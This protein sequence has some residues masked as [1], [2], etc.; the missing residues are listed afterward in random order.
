MKRKISSKPK[1][2]LSDR[3][4]IAFQMVDLENLLPIKHRA[5]DIWNF[6][7]EMDLS[8]IYS[9]IRSIEGGAG[10]SAID[11]K[12]LMSLWIM[13]SAN[14]VGSARALDQLCREHRAYMWLC[15]GVSVNYHTLSDFRI[16]H[17]EGLNSLLVQG[18]AA[19]MKSG[20]LKLK[21]V[22]QDGMKI[23]ANSG[24]A[25]L[26]RQE[27]LENCLKEASA[28]IESLKQELKSSPMKYSRKR[29]AALIRARLERKNRVREAIENLAEIKKGLAKR[30]RKTIDKKGEN[31]RASTTDP[32]SRILKMPNGGYDVAFNAQLA[33]DTKTGIIVGL[34]IV[35]VV[36]QGQ[37]API[38]EQI[39]ANFK[40]APQEYLVDG[41]FV[42]VDDICSVSNNKAHTNVYAPV[43]IT[44]Q[45]NKAFGSSSNDPAI[46]KWRKRMDSKKGKKI[47]KDRASTAEWVNACLRNWGLWRIAVRGIAKARCVLL[48]YALTH[49]LFRIKA[50]AQT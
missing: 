27:T 4:Q 33:T 41:G 2:K 37:M 15:G 24:K 9:K 42:T 32:E 13:A 39:Q 43:P 12:I 23:R 47:Y 30:H 50:I 31:V 7:Q 36:D 8:L 44:G 19:L 17:G 28:R 26:H 18:V 21:R 34:D 22:A 35:N 11:P 25:S 48:W 1:L 45:Q 20:T 49:N 14:G 3:S 46:L 10:R 16:D 6:V 38:V 29:K 5:R 40:K